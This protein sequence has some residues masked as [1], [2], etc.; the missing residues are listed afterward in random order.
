MIDWNAH[1][2][3]PLSNLFGEKIYY[4]PMDGDGFETIGIY[5]EAYRE[6]ASI[7][8]G[9]AMSTECPTIGICAGNLSGHMPVEGDMVTLERTREIFQVN[10]V[11]PDGK[12]DYRLMLN[13]AGEEDALQE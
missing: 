8:D 4:Q 6:I 12:G 7:G 11:R 10:N 5:D 2:L 1:V 13:L 9:V 3:M